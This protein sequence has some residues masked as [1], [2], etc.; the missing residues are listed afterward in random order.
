MSS[1]GAVRME[2]WVALLLIGVQV[3]LVIR[4]RRRS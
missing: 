1:L 3:W 4:A 2:Q